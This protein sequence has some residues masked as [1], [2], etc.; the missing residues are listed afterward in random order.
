MNLFLLTAFLLGLAGSFH[1]A[2]MC[3]PLMLLMPSG[4]NNTLRLVISRLIYNAGR[5][6]TY[7]VIGLI[8]GLLGLAVSMKQFQKEISLATGLLIILITIFSFRRITI[9]NK[10]TEF[11]TSSFRKR[12]KKLYS[13]RNLFS[14]LSIGMLNGMLPCGFVYLAASAA[15]VSSGVIPGI[16]YMISFG[17]GTLPMMMTLSLIDKIFPAGIRKAIN[18]AAPVIA[19]SLAVFLIYRGAVMKNCICEAKE[20]AKCF[21]PVGQ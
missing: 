13:D 12:L 7:V 4:E 19:I 17:L 15:F 6:I 9:A 21:A 16:L 1:C 14:V 18:R 8:S 2:G 20:T 3:G 10:F 11:I 5:I